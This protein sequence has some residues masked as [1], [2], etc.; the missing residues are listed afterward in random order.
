MRTE[1]INCFHE[2]PNDSDVMDPIDRERVLATAT[3][4]AIARQSGLPV[5]VMK[6]VRRGGTG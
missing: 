3:R 2:N 1:E 6:Q 4:D 5:G